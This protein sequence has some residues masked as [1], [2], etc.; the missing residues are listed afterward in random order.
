MTIGGML[1]SNM[2]VVFCL[3][4]ECLYDIIVSFEVEI[5]ESVTWVVLFYWINSV[6]VEV[7]DETVVLYFEFGGWFALCV[8]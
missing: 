1:S 6:F 4:V 2:L 7:D 5:F 8:R 3:G